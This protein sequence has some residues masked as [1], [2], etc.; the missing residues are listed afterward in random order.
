MVKKKRKFSGMNHLQ[1]KKRKKIETKTKTTTIKSKLKI[2]RK[3]IRRYVENAN[4]IRI[5]TLLFINWLFETQTLDSRFIISQQW[6]NQVQKCFLKDFRFRQISPKQYNL[7]LNEKKDNKLNPEQIKEQNTKYKEDHVKNQLQV[8]QITQW[9]NLFKKEYPVKFISDCPERILSFQSRKILMNLIEF[10]RLDDNVLHYTKRIHFQLWSLLNEKWLHPNKM[11]FPMTKRMTE[12]HVILEKVPELFDLFVVVNQHQ[13]LQDKKDYINGFDV[14]VSRINY[15]KCLRKVSEK[16]I[17]LCP[18]A[19]FVP[20][21]I[22]FD[23]NTMKSIQKL[24]FKEAFMSDGYSFCQSS[25]EEIKTKDLPTKEIDLPDPS[26]FDI[27][28][29]CDPGVKIPI[30]MTT[31]ETQTHFNSIPENL[32]YLNQ[33]VS[34]YIRTQQDWSKSIGTD[35]YNSFYKTRLVNIEAIL[36]DLSKCTSTLEYIKTVYSNYYLLVYEFGHCDYRQWRFRRYGMKQRTLEMV[37]Q[38]IQERA[39]R[40]QD[41]HFS[42][43]DLQTKRNTRRR[44]KMLKLSIKKKV[45]IYWGNGNFNHTFK[46]NQ[47]SSCHQIRDF[48]MKSKDIEVVITNESRTSKCCLQCEEE[49]TKSMIPIGSYRLRMCTDCLSDNKPCF[50]ERDFG[51]ASFILKRGLDKYYEENGMLIDTIL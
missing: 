35:V 21:H 44:K 47:T 50:S 14:L 2:A 27:V 48:L 49:Y 43:S 45:L 51:S 42:E 4:E 11:I 34:G 29:G 6:L 3:E 23:T 40:D 1:T 16:L 10:Y 24:G 38:H 41:I 15:L 46:N 7:K 37:I 36:L 5:Q 9:F 31:T 20:G 12:A 39:S 26:S 17:Y 22:H 33:S 32:K 28:Y 30:C 13:Q 8:I 19:S 18:R 25:K